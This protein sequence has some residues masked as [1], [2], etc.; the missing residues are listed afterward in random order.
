MAEIT[1]LKSSPYSGFLRKFLLVSGIMLISGSFFSQELPRQQKPGKKMIEVLNA[2]EGIDEV[3][4]VTGRRV[5]RLLRNVSLKQEDVFM[6]CDSAWFYPGVN[7][8]KAYS[9][10]HMYQGD[11]LH[12]YGDSLF[13]DGMT[14]QAS[15]HGNVEMVDKETH[16]F[17]NAVEYDVANDIAR[18]NTG[19]RITNGDNT[20]TSIIGIYY[21]AQNLFHS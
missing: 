21:V 5:T 13:Y 14:R 12:L 1:A 6:T 4:R 2:D 17:T 20:L 19:G 8:V 9:R 11:T 15:V 7:Q 10:I 18:Y 3:E 16:L